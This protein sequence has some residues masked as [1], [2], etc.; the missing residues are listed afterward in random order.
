MIN[1]GEIGERV[2][3]GIVKE[4]LRRLEQIEKSIPRP[5][6]ATD[7]PLDV[8]LERFNRLQAVDQMG[9]E[10]Q[11]QLMAEG[12]VE[13]AQRWG[14]VGTSALS[15]LYGRKAVAQEYNELHPL[16]KKAQEVEGG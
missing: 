8:R 9:R 7:S 16:W 12:N 11:E 15:K 10:R 1:L 14:P 5:L 6:G 2:A 3:D 4:G 13:E